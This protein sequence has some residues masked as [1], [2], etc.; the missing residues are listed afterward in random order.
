[1]IRCFDNTI[2][3]RKKLPLKDDMMPLIKARL[4][5]IFMILLGNS[6]WR[7]RWLDFRNGHSIYL[8]FIMTF[9][10]F[11][12]IQYRLLIDRVPVV[13]SIFSSIWI[14]ALVFI[15]IYVPLGMAIGYWHRKSQF[16]V[17]AEALFSQN[18]IGATIYLFLI[19][20]IDGKVTEEEKQSM[21]NYLMKIMKR[22]S[23]PSV[24]GNMDINKSSQAEPK[25][26]AERAE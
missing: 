21:R 1:V 25:M 18:Q 22:N 20:L 12:T 19:D 17:E 14:F 23:P 6:N 13:H 10:N 26:N 16:S 11:V 4:P 24:N 15:A 7:R 2:I 8:I 3:Q 5:R 9:A